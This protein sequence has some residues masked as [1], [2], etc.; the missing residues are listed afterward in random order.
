MVLSWKREEAD[1]MKENC[2]KLA[3]GRSRFNDRKLF[4]AGKEKKADLMKEN[5]LKLAK[6]RSRFND[7]KLFQAS[8]GKKQI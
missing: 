3:K 6:G 2:F 8:K 4:E 5:S 7:R 1:L